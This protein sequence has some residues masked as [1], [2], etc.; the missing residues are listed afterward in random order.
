MGEAGVTGDPDVTAVAGAIGAICVVGS[1]VV[2]G[3]VLRK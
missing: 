1:G 3:V 2:P